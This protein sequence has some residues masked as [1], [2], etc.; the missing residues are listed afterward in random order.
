[1]TDISQLLQ[2][3]FSGLTA[4][5]MYALIAVSLVIV[6]KVSLLI[7]FAQGEFFVIGALTMVTFVSKGL[8]MPLAFVASVVVAATL[9]AVV[10]R[11]LDQAYPER[12]SRNPDCHDDR[13]IPHLTG[14]GPPHLG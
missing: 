4:G 2:F 1:M 12:G 7:C 10:E 13:H 8:P 11:F 6:Y 3:L 5:S 14:I 9:G